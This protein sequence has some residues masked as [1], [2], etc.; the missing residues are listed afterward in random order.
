MNEYTSYYTWK[1]PISQHCLGH[2]D[3]VVSC[4]VKWAGI[5]CEMMDEDEKHNQYTA[6]YKFLN[7]LEDGVCCEFHFWRE[8][9]RATAARYIE[10]NKHMVRAHDI[11]GALREEHA[12]N[13]SQFAWGNEV[14]FIFS[15]KLKP[16]V[17]KPKAKKLFKLQVAAA[18][19]LYRAVN[20]HIRFL[21]GAELADVN[22][23]CRRINQ[24][25]NRAMYLK[26]SR[27]NLDYRFD[28]SEQ[29]IREKPDLEDGCLKI[30]DQYSKVLLMYLYPDADPGWFLCFA[31]IV[32]EMHITQIVYPIK[33]REEVARQ[34][35]EARKESLAV[36]EASED[37]EI[38]AISERQEFARFVAENNLKIFRNAFII[39]LHG[40]KADIK[41][42]A[43]T[44]IDFINDHGGDVRADADIQYHFFRVGQPGMGM[45]TQFLRPDHTLQIA[46]MNPAVTFDQGVKDGEIL[47]VTSSGQLVTFSFLKTQAPHAFTVA[48]TRSGKGVDKTCEI[49]ETYPMGLNWYICEFG[50]TYRW[51]VEAF[52]GDYTIVDPDKT[53]VNPLPSYD[54]A[55]PTAGNPLTAALSAGTILGLTFLLIDGRLNSNKKLMLTA[56]EDAAASIALNNLYRSPKK[57]VRTPSLVDFAYALK[58]SEY[59]SKEQE[60]AGRFM[61]SNLSSFL[62]SS[63]GGI[64]KND[65]NFILTENITGVDLKALE[66]TSPKLLIFY[67]NAIAQKYS[68]MIFFKSDQPGRALYDE[69]HVPVRVAPHEM[70]AFASSIARMG[71]KA[72]GFIDLVT[73]GLSELDVLDEV[74]SSTSIRSL[75]YRSDLWAEYVKRLE[76]PET[77][78]RIWQSYGSPQGL[79]YRQGLKYVDGIYYDLFLKFTDN[80]LDIADTNPK[81]MAWKEII[82]QATPHLYE[83]IGMLRAY[84]NNDKEAA[85]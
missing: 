82:T 61:Y 54:M 73:Q 12:K 19:E 5:Q 45:Y 49:V 13:L 20:K 3:G 57:G 64:F 80:L 10:N 18:R 40:S 84:R 59:K 68:Q 44:I 24:S 32:C 72:N 1:T 58:S 74:I 35:K 71:G 28:I 47:R 27:V 4:M 39:H 50:S 83:R 7:Q 2:S 75:L 48:K 37:F 23:Y 53:I 69:I 77:P 29:L 46:N 65:D 9:D 14:A 15:K 79:N 33:T 41:K 70:N 25:Y 38:K 31:S 63:I 34:K 52:G 21:P 62:D 51:V 55:E 78:A 16:S 42:Q 43:D 22:E 26:R 60:E 8:R 36:A 81:E 30:G 76:I 67:L 66:N 56:P 11:G 6:L 85:A 17:F